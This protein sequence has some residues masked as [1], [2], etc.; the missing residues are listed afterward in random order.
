MQ[1]TINNVHNYRNLWELMF[2]N[3]IYEV[4]TCYSMERDSFICYIATEDELCMRHFKDSECNKQSME[5]RHK[6]CTEEDQLNSLQMHFK[7][8]VH[9]WGSS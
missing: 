9:F 2:E 8:R 6:A 7:K 3:I 5:F 4:L 1:N